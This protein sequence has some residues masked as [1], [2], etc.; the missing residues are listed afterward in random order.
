MK[1]APSCAVENAPCEK[2][3][4]QFY[5][6]MITGLGGPPAHACI[7]FSSERRYYFVVELLKL[8]GM[9]AFLVWVLD[10]PPKRREPP[11]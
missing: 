7:S 9:L 3:P 1:P 5:A 10:F 8:S 6:E 4:R 11:K 2:Q